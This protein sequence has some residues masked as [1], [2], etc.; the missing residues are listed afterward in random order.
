MK[1]QSTSNKFDE[2][3]KKWRIK[4]NES[5][6]THV[7]FKIHNQICL[8][9]QMGNVAAPIKPKW[10][11]WTCVFMENQYGQS[12]SKS[13]ET[14]SNESETNTLARVKI[15]AINTKQTSLIQSN[16]HIHL[17]FWHSD[18][19]DSLNFQQRNPPA[20]PIQDSRIHFECTLV[21]IKPQ[22]S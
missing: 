14:H 19:G 3:A 11:T 21:Q 12:T 7:A 4:I 2:W 5:E 8:T 13:K 15:S 10:N 17:N 18:K 6:C 1:L 20:L 16:T 22:D 9:V